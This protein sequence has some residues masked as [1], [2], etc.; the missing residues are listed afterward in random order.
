MRARLARSP[1]LVLGWRGDWQLAA[2]D[3]EWVRA[4]FLCI[5]PEAGELCVHVNEL[6]ALTGDRLTGALPTYRGEGRAFG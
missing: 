5:T 4:R 6:H 2:P 1:L 3:R